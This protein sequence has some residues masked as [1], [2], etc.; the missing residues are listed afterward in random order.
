MLPPPR[1]DALTRALAACR[2]QFGA[3]GVFS[4]VVNLLQLTVSL[5]MMQ[6]FDRVL[7][8]RSLD[9]LLWLTVVAV[10]AIG[11]MALLEGVR[12]M[13]MQRLALWLEARTAPEGFARALEATLRNRPYRMEVLRDLGTCR[14]WLSGPGALAV[15]DVPWVP[16]YLFVIYLLNPIL[17]IIATGGAVVL[18]GLALATELSTAG[19]LRK[20]NLS[21]MA[22]QK[23]ADAI[24]RNAEA[25]DAMGM[26][27]ALLRLWQ[28]GLSEALPLQ[29]KATDRSAFLS[30][31]TKFVRLAVQ[32]AVLG[33]GAYLTLHQQMTS[34][35]AI[36]GSIIM[37][38]ALAPVE[39]LIGGWKGLVQ[40]RQSYRRLRSFLAMPRLR[41]E[42]EPLPAPR[43][44]LTAE[45]LTWAP[46]GANTAVI[47]G[48]TFALEPGESL[49][50]IGP[51][52]SGKTT[53]LRLLVG[54]LAPVSGAAR[55]D[56][57]DLSAW[58]REDLGRHIGYL[59][60]DVELFEGT[61]FRNI[62]RLLPDAE[63]NAVYRAAGLAGCHEAI[64]RLPQG[65]E[66]EVVEGALSGGQ[67]QMVGLAR[68]LYGDPRLVILDEPDSSL[69][70]DAE[71]RLL[72]GLAGL[73]AIG[74]TVVLVSHR[75]SLIR[76]VD[77]VLVMRDGAA[78]LFGPRAE[79]LNRLSA[80][81][82]APGKP[83]APE[84]LSAGG[85]A[86]AGTQVAGPPDG[87]N[88]RQ[89]GVAA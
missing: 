55:L 18:F 13:T 83:A 68:A 35:A 82:V 70:G 31:F 72:E 27:P 14:A 19:P 32:I 17:C 53:L 54:T 67:R 1:P 84:R 69:D 29:Q 34:G 11:L 8:T 45:R 50:I 64:L 63:P 60:Q 25:A 88:P 75:P 42:A 30:G 79:V 40:A 20:A 48:V 51:S 22:S 9:T 73:K 4:L 80:R 5:Y 2:S 62:S 41:P 52:G 33:V 6:V 78:E 21:A 58:P 39:Q 74:A 26:L 65:Y 77:K 24:A 87:P 86:P 15:Y 23:R 7:A 3:V 16:V 57:A 38:R 61:V 66:T 76:G 44:Q 43:G 36:A 12:S 10:A 59:P 71:A 89:P 85:P 46:P 37:G 49:G 47:K 28:G 56:G 81:A